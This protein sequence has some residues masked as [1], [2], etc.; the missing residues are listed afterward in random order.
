M[1]NEQ[2]Q[3]IKFKQRV[4]FSQ[5]DNNLIESD[6]ISGTAFK[7]WCYLFSRPEGWTFYWSNILQ[8]MKEGRDAVK[9]AVNELE[10]QGYVAKEQKKIFTGRGKE[11]RWGGM[12]I[13]V[14]YDP[15]ENPQFVRSLAPEGSSPIT[16]NPST[17]NPTSGDASTGKPSTINKNKNNTDF[18]N[19]ESSSSLPSIEIAKK[20]AEEEDLK[21]DVENWYKN[22]KHEEIRN[23]KK[24]M[25]A[26][27]KNPKNRVYE[28]SAPIEKLPEILEMENEI[29]KAMRG[30]HNSS[31][32]DVYFL[33]NIELVEGEFFLKKKV[34]AKFD[35][36]SEQFNLKSR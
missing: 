22:S 11:W 27:A 14:F 15:M 5:I 8:K 16:E 25:I 20:F 32:F 36:V 28:K 17:G 24:A 33:G 13:S 10:K 35:W 31:D 6:K 1:T 9:N 29:K 30:R 2:Q 3:T 12:E 26:W 7:I 4:N 18:N 23:W 34:P 19:T 21:I